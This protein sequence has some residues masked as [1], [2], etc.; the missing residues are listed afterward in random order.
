MHTGYIE[1]CH[2]PRHNLWWYLREEEHHDPVFCN[3]LETGDFIPCGTSGDSPWVVRNNTITTDQSVCIPPGYR[4]CNFV[5][6]K[7]CNDLQL[8]RRWSCCGKAL[9]G[10]LDDMRKF[11]G[12][13]VLYHPKDHHPRDD[14]D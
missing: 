9:I 12:C 14:E 7:L 8:Y 4:C 3:N 1:S 11:T 2:F 10:T 5:R 6:G 13:D